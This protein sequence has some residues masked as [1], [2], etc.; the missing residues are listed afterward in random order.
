MVLACVL[1]LIAKG[2]AWLL[3]QVL[4]K[5]EMRR[6]GLVMMIR[7][8]GPMNVDVMAMMIAYVYS[9]WN[10]YNTTEQNNSAISMDG[11]SGPSRRKKYE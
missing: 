11:P 6:M 5:T 1:L 3:V 2:F 8:Q 10:L 9:A 7:P 4:K